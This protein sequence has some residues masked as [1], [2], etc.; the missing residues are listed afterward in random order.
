MQEKSSHNSQKPLRVHL[1]LQ[2]CGGRSG[3][4][5]YETE[6][7]LRL[8]GY[9]DIDISASYFSLT[10]KNTERFNFPMRQIKFHPYLAF[11]C[12]F[13][14]KTAAMSLLNFTRPFFSCNALMKGGSDDVYMF[15]ENKIPEIRLK[16]KIIAV[17]H[18][19]IPLRKSSIETFKGRIHFRS[20]KHD[21]ERILARADKIIT[22]SEY[23]KSDILD[24]FGL[25]DNGKIE[26][27]YCGADV[28]DFS[29]SYDFDT[30]RKEYG[31][32]EKYMLY[33][34]RCA[35]HKNL[36]SLVKA[37]SLLPE[38][39]REEYKI[40]ITNPDS[41]VIHCAEK[42]GVSDNM[43]WIYRVP[44]KDRPG[45]YQA[46]SLIV[47]PSF[48]E[49]FGLQ[50]VEGMAAG[51]PVLCSN[52]TSMPEVAGDSAILIDPNNIQDISQGIERGLTDENLR[53]E[54]I[55]KGYENIKRFS[56]DKSAE[57]IHGIITSL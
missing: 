48:Y 5:T 21:I 43:R 3:F 13:N 50:I 22:D 12:G 6:I 56:W 33:F 29:R 27:V 25:N 14:R 10:E 23:S 42:C 45:I 37:Y 17:I 11:N 16:G 9:K 18:D 44:D 26:V 2:S 46:A 24:F 40:V 41:S 52:V 57:K 39:L 34:G 54:L 51:V 36:C 32:P 55:R 4:A 38:R 28:S 47:L 31:L 15:F 1:N 49:G 19:I 8:A 7:A 35:P 20:A 53:A 30:L